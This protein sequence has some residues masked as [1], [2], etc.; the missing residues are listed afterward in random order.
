MSENRL[1]RLALPVL[2]LVL[3]IV[4]WH[5][6][7]VAFDVPVAVLPRPALVLDSMI[8]NWRL[9]VEEG[10][11]TLLESLY[12]FILAFVLGVPLAVAIA[13]SRTLNLMFYPLLIATQSLPKVALAPH[14]HLARHRHGIQARHRLAR[15]VLP[16]RGRHRD[17][18]SQHP[19]GI[20]RPRHGGAGK[21]LSDLLENS[22]SGRDAVRHLG[23]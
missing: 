16:D 2:G 12:G 14:S 15:R 10:W 20:P 22:I 17:R 13:G 23:V 1:V 7:V 6:Y 18:A 21:P 9:I 11:I 4:G 19:G 3:L 8:A 5:A